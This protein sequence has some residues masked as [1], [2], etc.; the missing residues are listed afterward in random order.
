MGVDDL[1]DAA[2]LGFDRGETVTIPP[3]ADE[4][5]W[6]RIQEGRLAFAPLMSKRDVAPR[7]RETV[8]A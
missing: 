7:Y 2:L 5:V 3:L 1:V 8:D 6:T 4:S